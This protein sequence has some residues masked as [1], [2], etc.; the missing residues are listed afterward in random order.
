MKKPNPDYS[1]TM[2]ITKGHSILAHSRSSTS[3]EFSL[4]IIK[5]IL[6]EYREN[7]TAQILY[8]FSTLGKCMTGVADRDSVYGK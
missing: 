7:K 6:S 4:F 2:I 5:Y 3:E 1:Y 8:P